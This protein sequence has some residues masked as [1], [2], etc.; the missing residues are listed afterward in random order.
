MKWIDAQEQKPKEGQQ[1]LMKIAFQ[2]FCGGSHCEDE[3]LI[4]G[5]IKDGGWYA[6]NEMMIWDYDFNL[7]FN[8][9]DVLSWVALTEVK[10]SAE[11][12]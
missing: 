8:E 10:D 7:G 6:G 4:T 2:R 12:I 3:I 1:V 9:D 11:G 5:G